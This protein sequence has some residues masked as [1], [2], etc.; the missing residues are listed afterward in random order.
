[1]GGSAAGGLSATPL[2]SAPSTTLG[3]GGFT[4]FPGFPATG[5]AVPAPGECGKWDYRNSCSHI[6]YNK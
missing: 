3:A 4:G 1:M 2:S 5:A 6:S